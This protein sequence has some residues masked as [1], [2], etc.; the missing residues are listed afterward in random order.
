VE[1]LMKCYG[2]V[3]HIINNC[4]KTYHHQMIQKFVDEY[5][6]YCSFPYWDDFSLYE[7]KQRHHYSSERSSDSPIGF[8]ES[9]FWSGRRSMQEVESSQKLTTSVRI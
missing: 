9:F 2:F 3:R 7:P 6:P 4:T 1:D 5:Y 8:S